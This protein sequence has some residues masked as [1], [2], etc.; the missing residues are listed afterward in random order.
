MRC[1]S[2]KNYNPNYTMNI[3]QWT[4]WKFNRPIECVLNRSLIRWFYWNNICLPLSTRD[5]NPSIFRLNDDLISINEIIIY[6]V[7]ERL[8][9]WFLLR[10]SHSSCFFYVYW[11]QEDLLCY[12]KFTGVVD[13][14]FEQSRSIDRIS[15]IHTYG[16][17]TYFLKI[18]VFYW[19]SF[20][21]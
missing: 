7:F 3:S 13:N 1:S 14:Q 2:N 20:L 8:F 18:S 6:P 10:Q 5:R 4:N 21:E 16:S 9:R 11:R 12:H 15:R 19:H 17:T